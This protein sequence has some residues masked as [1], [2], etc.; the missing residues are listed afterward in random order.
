LSV[1][2]VCAQDEFVSFFNEGD[3]A[4]GE[5]KVHALFFAPRFHA[6]C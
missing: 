6:G 3:D 4:G 1:V 2:V 5:D